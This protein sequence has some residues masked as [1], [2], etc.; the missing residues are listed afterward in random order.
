MATKGKK[1]PKLGELE[2]AVLEAICFATES[3]NVADSLKKI[4]GEDLWEDLMG[5]VNDPRVIGFW[6]P[7]VT[8]VQVE[9][10]ANKHLRFQPEQYRKDWNIAEIQNT[11]HKVDL[12]LD[13]M[14]KNNDAGTVYGMIA[15]WLAE[16]IQGDYHLSAE[17]GGYFPGKAKDYFSCFFQKETDAMAVKL[18]WLGQEAI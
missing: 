18:A 4:R 10:F 2:V 12:P 14:L 1:Y 9:E 7:D 8:Q 13:E 17:A 15:D 11:W 3:S 6:G 5:I 16:N